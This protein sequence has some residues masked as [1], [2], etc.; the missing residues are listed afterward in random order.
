MGMV[1]HE[2]TPSTAAQ[3]TVTIEVCCT[4]LF[5]EHWVKLMRELLVSLTLIKL[6]Q[7]A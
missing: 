3:H 7:S 2:Y 4:H 1:A 5:E 6:V